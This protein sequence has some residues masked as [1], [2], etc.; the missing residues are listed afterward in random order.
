[1]DFQGK[2]SGAVPLSMTVVSPLS[3]KK[4]CSRKVSGLLAGIRG[5]GSNFL[6]GDL[7]RV[8]KYFELFYN[9]GYRTT[10]VIEVDK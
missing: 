4:A 10:N 2:A 3:N 5:C 6:V 8:E 1:M 9:D 7:G